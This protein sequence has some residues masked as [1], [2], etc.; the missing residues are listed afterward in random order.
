MCVYGSE[1]N[2]G[3]SVESGR[4]ATDEKKSQRCSVVAR[5]GVQSRFGPEV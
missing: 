4:V 1:K 3:I 2:V 5:V